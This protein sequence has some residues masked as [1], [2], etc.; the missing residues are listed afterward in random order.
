MVKVI[1]TIFPIDVAGLEVIDIVYIGIWMVTVSIL[2]DLMESVIKRAV[3]VK[4]SSAIAIV[5]K[6][7]GILDKFDS[8]GVAWITM[9]IALR[10]YRPELLP[11]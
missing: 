11:Y 9:S 8:L 3:G 5:G 2:G 4:D 1:T 6:L 10:Y 7:G